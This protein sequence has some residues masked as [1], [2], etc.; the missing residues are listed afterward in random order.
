MVGSDL[1]RNLRFLC[2]F[3]KSVSEVCRAI[4]IN[5]QQF[6]KYLNGSSQPS[7]YNMQRICS[8]FSIRPADLLLPHDEL[9]GRFEFRAAGGERRVGSASRRVFARAFPGDGAGLRRYV[10][11]YLTHCHSFSWEG[12]LLRAITQVFE[13]DGL[14]GIKTIERT[15]DPEDGALFLSKYDGQM[16]LLGNRL[17][18]IEH[19]SLAND[20]IV[21]TVLY[22]TARSQLTLLRG[23]T[24]GLSSK[25]RNPYVSRCVWKYL[26]STIDLKRALQATGLY[27]SDSK[28]VDP[29]IARIL[30][31]RPF[32]NELLHYDLEPH[33]VS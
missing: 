11:Y 2:D 22:P 6:S 4:G 31:S 33:G 23:V 10:G 17:F 8:Y 21:E 24:F 32:P 27:A 18:V 5:R 19:Q 26:G 15:R 1:S 20:A 12:H 30:G 7:P 28:R 3:E 14:Y 13:R 16:S 25:H 9:A 29:K